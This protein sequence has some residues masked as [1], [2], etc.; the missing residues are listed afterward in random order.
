MNRREANRRGANSGGDNRRRANS[1]GD[2]RR[3][4]NSGEANRRGADSRGPES[5]YRQRRTAK[6]LLQ[7]AAEGIGVVVALALGAI[8]TGLV[9]SVVVALLF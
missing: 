4:A 2:N 3:G 9:L 8:L 1:G 7:Q 5:A 6:P